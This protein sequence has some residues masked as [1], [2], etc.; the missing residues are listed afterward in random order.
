MPRLA[1]PFV[2][3]PTLQFR[4]LVTWTKLPGVT[5]HARSATQPQIN[6][7]PIKVDYNMT[8]FY[9][10]GKTDW[11]P[12]TLQCYQFEGITRLE[13]SL[14]LEKQHTSVG[15]DGPYELGIG[16]MQ[17]FILNPMSIPIGFWTLINPWIANYDFGQMDWGSEDVAQASL[18]IQYDHAKYVG[19]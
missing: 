17:I 5:L 16:Q 13:L 14:Y 10:K 1:S 2:L 12:I 3:H 18:T 8:S 4:Y 15:I 7:N 6:N 11:D 19:L 9:V